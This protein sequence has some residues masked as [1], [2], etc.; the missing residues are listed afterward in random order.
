MTTARTEQLGLTAADD[1]RAAMQGKVVLQGDA[2]YADVRRIWNGAVSRQ[3]L[4]FALCETL[5]DV[6]AAVHIAAAH[7]LPLSVRGGGHDSV[8]RALR[9]GGLVID[10]SRMRQVEVDMHERVATVAGGATAADLMAALPSGLVAV[11]G[12]IGAVGMGGF[13]LGGGYSHF[14]SRF[15]LA[16][17]NLLGAEVVLADGRVVRADASQNSDLFWALRGGGGNFGVITEMRIRLHPVSQLLAGLI[18]F[19]WSQAASI[20]RAHNQIISSAPDE[21]S[22]QVGAAP[23]PDG[24][25]LF[26]LVPVWT[27][28]LAQG[29]EIIARLQALGTPVVTQVAPMQPLE[30]VR[31]FDDHIVS[32][33]HRAMRTRWLADLT[34][35]TISALVRAGEERTSPF[36]FWVLHHLHGVGT[37]VASDATAFG[38]RR[39][40]FMLEIGAA[41]EPSSMTDGD[42]HRRWVS[43]LWS[44]LA[45]LALPGGYANFLTSDDHE[46]IASAYG[47]NG[48]RLRQVKRQYDPDNV[49]S[50]AIP[51]PLD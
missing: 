39:K 27:G 24:N 5:R 38:M 36:S 33:Q 21:L 50:S 35:E 12:N 15:G 44:I 14:S 34:P 42:V 16:V 37:R 17:D 8:G 13:L 43:D 49:F 45:P 4:M 23:A 46:Q 7:N 10:L 25:L 9:D 19:P 6:Q 32:G 1:L 18:L 51:L 3:P 48:S 47:N 30:L 28:G 29:E 20:M 40:H 26:F 31:L 41:W 11:T 22:V 2:S